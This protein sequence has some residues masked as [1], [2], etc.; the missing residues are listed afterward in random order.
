MHLPMKTAVYMGDGV[1]Y[2][3]TTRS[4]IF[5]LNQEGYPVK[6]RLAF[7]SPED[8]AVMNYAYNVSDTQYDEVFLFFERP[9]D[10]ER[11]EPIVRQFTGLSAINIVDFT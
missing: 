9:M 2:H 6:N 3:S 8:P 7:E 4:P 5:P 1:S 11:L 10:D